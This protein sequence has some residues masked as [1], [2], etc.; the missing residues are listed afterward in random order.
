MLESIGTAIGSVKMATDIARGLIAASGSVEKAELKL[1]IAEI[2]TALA[3][4]RLAL[5]DV[6]ESLAG[7]DV[8]IAEL[9]AAFSVKESLVRLYDA[10]YRVSPEGK[11]TGLPFCLRCWDVDHQQRPLVSSAINHRVTF[12]N[13]CKSSYNSTHT[14]RLDEA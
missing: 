14:P 8:R 10:Y 1:K 3:E 11:P 9:E 4:A 12:C 5:V 13:V 2:A 6:Q 7:K